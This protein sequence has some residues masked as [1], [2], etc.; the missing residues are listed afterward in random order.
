MPILLGGI[1]VALDIADDLAEGLG[2]G[3]EAEGAFDVLVLQVAV[4]GLGAADHL[5]AGVVGGKVLGQHSRVGVG[6][7]AADD[8][9]GVDAVLFAVFGN[10]GKLLL[11]FPAWCVPE[12]MMSKPP[13]L[14][15]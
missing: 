4:D 14:R 1:G 13:V 7:V 11:V 3:V 5:H 12:P 15:Y 8:H 2:G 9:D 10:D 6:I